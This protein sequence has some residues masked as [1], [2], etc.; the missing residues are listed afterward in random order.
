MVLN[1]R[2]LSDV[3]GKDVIAGPGFFGGGERGVGLM[4]W[5]SQPIF[6]KNG[7]VMPYHCKRKLH[8]KIY[9]KGISLNGKSC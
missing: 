3:Q 1:K 4:Q 9:T 7:G 6:A 2:L 5:A 8:A